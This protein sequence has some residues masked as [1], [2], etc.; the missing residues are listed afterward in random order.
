MTDV[1]ID[2]LAVET[3]QPRGITGQ[4]QSVQWFAMAVAGLLVGVGGGYVAE[5]QPQR[6]MFV[7]CGVWPWRR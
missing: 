6:P 4:I 7:G 1:T 5:H 3:G 2:A